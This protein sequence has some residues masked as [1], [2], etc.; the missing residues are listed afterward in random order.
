MNLDKTILLH[1]FKCKNIRMKPVV[2][3]NNRID[4]VSSSKENHLIILQ[5]YMQI[6]KIVEKEI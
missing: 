5:Q 4:N 6:L 1:G 3:E 2:F